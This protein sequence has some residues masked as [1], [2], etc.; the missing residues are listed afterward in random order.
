MTTQTPY[1]FIYVT[2]GS[3]DEATQ[4]GR[5][6]VER[7]LV[8][9]ANVLDGMSAI[10]WW[11]GRVEESSEAILIA[12]TTSDHVAAVTEAIR[13]RHSYECPCVIALPITEGSAAYL[14]WVHDETHPRP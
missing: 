7:R 3:R 6:L 13:E 4:L 10:Y 8:A 1:R 14:D 12:K 5:M 11:Q 9:C 2:A